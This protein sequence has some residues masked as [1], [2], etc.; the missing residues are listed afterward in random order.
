MFITNF[1]ASRKKKWHVHP[2]KTRISLGI[3]PVWWESSLSAWRKLGSL[4]IHWADSEDSDQTGQR[5]RLIWVFA[6][7]T[8]I[9][10]V[11]SWGGSNFKASRKKI[12]LKLNHKIIWAPSSENVSSRVCDQ[13]TFKPACSSTETSLNLEISDLETRDI[14]LSKERTTKALIRLR[15]CAGWSAPLLFAYDI[16]HIFAWPGPFIKKKKFHE[17]LKNE[18]FMRTLYNFNATVS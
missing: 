14:L 9:L 3:C 17:V 8:V 4:A 16:R 10:L 13:V 1:K 18:S 11:L 5:P 6:G 15:G 12:E 2:V 7:R